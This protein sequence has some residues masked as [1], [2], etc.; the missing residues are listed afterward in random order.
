M[1]GCRAAGAVFYN[2]VVLLRMLGPAPM[3]MRS[4][5][6]R[7]GAKVQP[8]RVQKLCTAATLP[9]CFACH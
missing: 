8:V 3:L 7:G 5:Y 6:M 1:S 9:G 2:D 4:T